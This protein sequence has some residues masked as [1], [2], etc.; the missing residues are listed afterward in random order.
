MEVV[1]PYQIYQVLDEVSSYLSDPHI[2]STNPRKMA[3][4]NL[5][6]KYVNFSKQQFSL[7]ESDIKILQITDVS[8]QIVIQ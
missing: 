8:D 3:E 1:N 5:M 2:N 6:V 4:P 7:F